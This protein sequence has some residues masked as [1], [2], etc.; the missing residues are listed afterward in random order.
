[1]VSLLINIW[2]QVHVM[3]CKRAAR[4]GCRGLLPNTGLLACHQALAPPPQG[5]WPER[6][7]EMNKNVMY[8][9]DYILPFPGLL[10]W[11]HQVFWNTLNFPCFLHTSI[12][13]TIHHIY[14]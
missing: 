7:M 13:P 4:K 8:Y 12:C 3:Y 11:C 1:M 14:F 2:L 5:L 6:G 10:W 9:N